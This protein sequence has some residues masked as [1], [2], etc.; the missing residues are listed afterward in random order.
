ML[1]LAKKH[2]HLSIIAK[3]ISNLP[4]NIKNIDYSTSIPLPSFRYQY[5]TVLLS[6]IQIVRD[7]IYKSINDHNC[8]KSVKLEQKKIEKSAK[9]QQTPDFSVEIP[10]SLK[11]LRRRL[12]LLS[13]SSKPTYV[14][15]HVFPIFR[16][17]EKACFE[18]GHQ[19]KC[20]TFL[21]HQNINNQKLQPTKQFHF[22]SL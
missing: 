22:Q 1:S 9:I 20:N 3:K 17:R 19:Q 14:A 12:H 18:Y 15:K 5:P 11:A 6:T 7:N 13:T 8:K 16:F 21:Y 2:P 4:H 10:K